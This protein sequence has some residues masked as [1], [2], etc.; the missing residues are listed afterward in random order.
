MR[1]RVL[2]IVLAVV[3]LAGCDQMIGDGVIRLDVTNRCD[4]TLFVQAADSERDVLWAYERPIAIAPND[5]KG[6]SLI[7]NAAHH[8][9]RYLLVYSTDQTSRS[10]H[11]AEVDVEKLSHGPYYAAF[12]P[13]CSSMTLGTTGH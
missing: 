7:V 12:E 6:V 11:V 9:D 3:I 1:A 10:P 5:W 13:D 4:V 2:A 8:P